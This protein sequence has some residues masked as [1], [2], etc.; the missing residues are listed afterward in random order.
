MQSLRGQLNQRTPFYF[1]TVVDRGV[2][3]DFFGEFTPI[4]DN[5]SL[6]VKFETRSR[7]IHEGNSS[8]TLP[9]NGNLYMAR[10]VESTLR[11]KGDQVVAIQLPRLS[12][13]ETGAFADRS[14]SIRIRT[15]QIR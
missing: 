12:E 1:D 9:V 7:L 14:D 2:S 10:R 4:F 6:V 3:L 11:L 5:G 8:L 13:N 15:K